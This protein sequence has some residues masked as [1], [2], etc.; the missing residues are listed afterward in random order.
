MWKDF[1]K[2][3]TNLHVLKWSIWW[4]AASCGYLQIVS[5]SQPV[6]QTAVK[7]NQKIYNGAVEAI[8]SIIGKLSLE[9]FSYLFFFLIQPIRNNNNNHKLFSMKNIIF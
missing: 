1:L 2:A 9:L 7:D 8:Y 6:W 5:Y 3:Y 4:A